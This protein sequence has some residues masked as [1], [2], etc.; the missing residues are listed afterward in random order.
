MKQWFRE[1]LAFEAHV[2]GT[3]SGWL[4]VA[5]GHIL[6]LAGQERRA[7]SLL[8]VIHRSDHSA[9]VNRSIERMLTNLLPRVYGRTRPGIATGNSNQRFEM[10]PW[11][12]LGKRAIVLKSPSVNERGVI[13]LDYMHTF[14]TFQRLFDVDAIG[15]R[16]YIVLE[17]SWVGACDPDI[18]GY[19]R[20]S[21]PVFV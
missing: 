8:S 6:R 20:Y 5:V 16:Y 11:K 12:L 9:A 1:W 17:P 4:G 10:D 13:L 7:L 3:A 15:Q 21:F 14:A 19:C 2:L 18:L